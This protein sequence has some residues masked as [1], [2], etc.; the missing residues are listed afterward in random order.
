MGVVESVGDA[1]DRIKVGDR[2]SLPFTIACGTCG[3]CSK[4]LTGFCLRANP[5][6]AGA[7]YGYASMG[8]YN[9]P[10]SSRPAGTESSWPSRA[11]SRSTTAP[12]SSRASPCSWC[13][14]A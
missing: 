10:T 14:T 7:A 6:S 4:G 9:C 5:G 1:V 3:N 8:P 2:V 13:P 11:S 12:S